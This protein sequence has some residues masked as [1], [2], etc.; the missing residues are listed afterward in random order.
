TGSRGPWAGCVARPSSRRADPLSDP[1][2]RSLTSWDHDVARTPRPPRR[3]PMSGFHIDDDDRPVGR[4][5]SRREVLVLF[6]G[7]GAALATGAIAA[8]ALVTS[9]ARGASATA[10]ALPSCVVVPALT[11]GPYFI[12]ERLD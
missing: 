4:V 3:C 11:E 6:G 5:L 1:S 12:D 8:G 9:P 7:T 2:Q 10:S